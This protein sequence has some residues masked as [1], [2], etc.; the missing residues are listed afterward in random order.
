MR[1]VA[2]YSH[3]RVTVRKGPHRRRAHSVRALAGGRPRA[4]AA[5]VGHFGDEE[6]E[7]GADLQ[8]SATP[9]V[10]RLRARRRV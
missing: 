6:V 7:L 5:V 3:G 8:H 2:P 10:R 4:Q 9:R 1:I